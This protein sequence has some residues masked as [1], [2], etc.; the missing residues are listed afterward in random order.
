MRVAFFSTLNNAPWGGC[1]VLWYKTALHLKQKGIAVSCFVTR[2]PKDPD[3]IVTLRSNGIEVFYFADHEIKAFK[4]IQSRMRQIIN[5]E[6]S[7]F[8]N[9]VSWNPDYVIFSQGHSYDLGYFK[10]ASI[11]DLI[12]SKVS[13]SIIALTFLGFILTPTLALITKLRY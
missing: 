10:D 12:N 4:K 9:L 5:K 11:C 2:W 3:H 6:K 13:Y 1:E 8:K 7:D